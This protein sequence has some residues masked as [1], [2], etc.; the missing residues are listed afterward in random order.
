MPAHLRIARPVND[1]GLS[2][3]LYRHGLEFSVLGQFEDHAGFDGVML[4]DEQA[5]YH[6]EF[7][8]NRRHPVRPTPTPED[9]LVFYVADEHEWD[10]RCKLMLEAG[11][12]EVRPFNPYWAG[13]GRSFEDPDHY[14]VVVQRSSWS[15]AKG[16]APEAVPKHAKD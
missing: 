6:L 8:H 3:R 15:N 16:L 7:T 13:Q 11:F 5:G 12:I 14:I 1:L 2:V 4:G 9:L 10:R